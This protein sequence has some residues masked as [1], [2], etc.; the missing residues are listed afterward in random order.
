MM[1]ED[2]CI[3]NKDKEQ[4]SRSKWDVL[5]ER[6]I[7]GYLAPLVLAYKSVIT[8]LLNIIPTC[9]TPNVR[10]PPYFFSLGL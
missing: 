6:S 8:F 9:L 2:Y 1:L 3:E 10:V 5:K 4:E 7:F